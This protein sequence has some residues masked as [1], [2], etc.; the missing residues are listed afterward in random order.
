MDDG[1]WQQSI[2]KAKI[3]SVNGNLDWCLVQKYG[4]VKICKWNLENLEL[5]L[6]QKYHI[7]V[8]LYLYQIYLLYQ[9]ELFFLIFP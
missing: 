7:T 2:D 1:F 8:I 9:L 3:W 5:V 4:M 6:G